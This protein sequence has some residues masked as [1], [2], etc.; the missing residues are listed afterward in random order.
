VFRATTSRA[1]VAGT[2][3]RTNYSTIYT[4]GFFTSSEIPISSITRVSGTTNATINFTS[5]H[6]LFPGQSIYVVDVNQNNAAHIGAFTI[7]QVISATA[8]RYSTN[9]VTAYTD[10]A[11]LSTAT[12]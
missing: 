6:G 2:N 5:P 7:L 4:G 3:Y 11:T 8:V 9:E 12:T 1:L 10:S